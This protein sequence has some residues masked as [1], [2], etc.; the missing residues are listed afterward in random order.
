MKLKLFIILA[1][2]VLSAC[3]SNPFIQ[4][5]EDADLV[6]LNHLA[7]WTG[8]IE[9]YYQVSGTYPFQNI[10]QDDDDII[11]V[12]I[13]TKDQMQYLSS[14]GDKYDQRID[15]NAHGRFN[16]RPVKEFVAEIESGL[17]YEIEEMYDI[18][19]VPTNS[20][21]GYYYFATKEGYLV[22]VTCLSCG[23]TQVSTLLMDGYTPT[24]N[25]GSPDMVAT[26]PKALTRSAMLKHPTYQSWVS[27]SFHR[28]EYVRSL[29]NENTSDSK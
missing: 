26:I 22:W 6:R 4:Y 7:Y 2:G 20:P 27:R 24:V 5:Q 15:N 11:L 29:V 9:D 16:E 19:K 13:A 14:D 23:V 25:I 8:V 18:Q 1:S 10:L 21:I 3:V 17:G 12:R 28:G